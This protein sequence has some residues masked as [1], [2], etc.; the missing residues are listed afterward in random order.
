MIKCPFGIEVVSYCS[1]QLPMFWLNLDVLAGSG[2][3][4]HTV[5]SALNVKVGPDWPQS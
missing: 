5:L 2:N 3:L 4:N 1:E